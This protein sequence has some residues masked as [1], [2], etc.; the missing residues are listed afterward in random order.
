[1]DTIDKLKALERWQVDSNTQKF[2]CQTDEN[3]EV[4][5]PFIKKQEVLM[6]CLNCGRIFKNLNERV[7]ELGR[8]LIL[9]DKGKRRK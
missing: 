9:Q 1:M 3:H 8:M 2:K 7:F 5:K 6:K 4:L